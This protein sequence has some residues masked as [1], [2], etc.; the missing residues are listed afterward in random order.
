MPKIV[1]IIYL[2]IQSLVNFFENL[3]V[4]IDNNEPLLLFCSE[5]CVT[6]E[7]NNSKFHIVGYNIIRCDS[8]SRYTGGVIIY[9][10]DHFKYNREYN[11]NIDNNIW[12]LCIEIKNTRFKGI[13]AC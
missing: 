8:H 11:R 1:Q 10:K 6:K 12:Y 7:I 9:I 13:Y 5:T 2:N 3:E 4:I